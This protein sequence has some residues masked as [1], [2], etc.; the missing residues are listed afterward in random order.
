MQ[1]QYKSTLQCPKCSR[2]S[3]TFD[4]YMSVPLPIPSSFRCQ[5]F[6]LPYR[7]QDKIFKY[8]LNVRMTDTM[9]DVKQQIA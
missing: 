9:M 3:V 6:F 8:E 7:I 1:G 5:Y 2:I 4:P